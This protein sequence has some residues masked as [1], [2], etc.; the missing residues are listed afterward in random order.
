[1]ALT[2]ITASLAANDVYSAP[3]SATQGL[4]LSLTGT[5]VATVTLQ[6]LQDNT[7]LASPT[8]VDVINAAGAI[9][10]FT[11]VGAYS[12]TV[13]NIAGVYRFGIKPSGYTS[14]TVAGVLAAR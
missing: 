3:I 11:T 6:R 14:G 9:T 4:V 13:P 1:M 7:T 10:T 2:S 8:W 12:I 5:F